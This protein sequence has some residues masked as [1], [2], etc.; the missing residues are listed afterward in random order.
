[1]SL[2]ESA[3]ETPMP[4][5]DWVANVLHRAHATAEALGAPDEARVIL[6]VAHA[7]ADELSN[8]DPQFDRVGFIEAATEGRS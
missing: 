2:I 1:M 4:V 7:F 8:A 6:H 5:D 3:R